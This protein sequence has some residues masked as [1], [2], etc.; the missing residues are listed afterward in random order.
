MKTSVK[1]WL[2]AI[3]YQTIIF[4][5]LF[6]AGGEVFILLPIEFIGGLP[7]LLIFHVVF[8]AIKNSNATLFQKWF[9]TVLGTIFSACFTSGLTLLLFFGML[10]NG[11]TL[12]TF[13]LV[14]PSAI[15]TILSLFSFYAPINRHF[16]QCS[17]QNNFPNELPESQT[18]QP[19]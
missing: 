18:D 15:A 16:V 14:I 12:E 6:R 11:L 8:N 1:I 9:N 7:G 3:L 19:I 5:F 10:E 17:L 2:L 13:M 4:A